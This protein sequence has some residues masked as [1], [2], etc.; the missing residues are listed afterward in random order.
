MSQQ[1]KRKRKAPSR[2]PEEVLQKKSKIPTSTSKKLM[3]IYTNK[4]GD[5]NIFFTDEKVKEIMTQLGKF[6]LYLLLEKSE[7]QIKNHISSQKS[8]IAKKSSTNSG[9]KLRSTI[10]NSED[11]YVNEDDF[12]ENDESILSENEEEICRLERKK[13]I[14]TV[15]SL[16]D[17]EEAKKS[18]DEKNESPKFKKRKESISSTVKLKEAQIKDIQKQQ[19]ERQEQKK[20]SDLMNTLLLSMLAKSS[21]LIENSFATNQT[22]NQVSN[23]T[24]NHSGESLIIDQKY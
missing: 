2:L 21:T 14:G 22:I 11:F 17:A 16:M 3:N 13:L 10:E 8:A 4:E 9:V 24:V 5:W 19:E 15:S 12:S 7:I 20:T 18:I 6:Y 1:E 23:Q